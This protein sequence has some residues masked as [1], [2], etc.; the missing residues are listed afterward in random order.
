MPFCLA[1]LEGHSLAAQVLP[2][3]QPSA[4]FRVADCAP[5]GYETIHRIVSLNASCPLRVRVPFEQKSKGKRIPTYVNVK[6]RD[7]TRLWFPESAA[8]TLADCRPRHNPAHSLHRPQDAVVAR[9]PLPKGSGVRF[10]LQPNKKAPT[11]VNAFLFGVLGGTRTPDPL[12]RSQILY[13]AELQAQK[14]LVF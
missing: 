14:C 2:A 5:L 6:K 12:V 13:P 4:W 9:F 8:H 10:N 7:S 3:Y 11:F 1:C